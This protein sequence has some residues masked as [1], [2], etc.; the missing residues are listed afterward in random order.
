MIRGERREK[1]ESVNI[2]QNLNSYA[3]VSTE[4]YLQDKIA[5]QLI[6]T[7]VH[8]LDLKIVPGRYIRAF[9]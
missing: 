3:L 8:K 2:T 9:Y 5:A 6:I 1:E 4:E 7:G